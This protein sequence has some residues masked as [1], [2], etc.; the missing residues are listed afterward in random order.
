MFATRIAEQ[1]KVS[2]SMIAALGE[3]RVSDSMIAAAAEQAKVS[4][5]FAT[6]IAEQVRVSDMVAGFLATKAIVPEARAS[7]TP[8][9]TCARCM[10]EFHFSFEKDALGTC[11]RSCTARLL[12]FEYGGEE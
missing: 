1:V 10:E 5:M 11:S 6:R 8:V 7:A 4:E 9:K 2:D 3:V 12:G